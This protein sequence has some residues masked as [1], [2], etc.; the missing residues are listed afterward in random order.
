MIGRPGDLL[1]GRHLLGQALDLE[2]VEVP[3]EVLLGDLEQVRR[4]LL[5]LGPDLAA[6]PGRRS[7]GDRRGARAVGAEAVGRGVGV[8]LLDLDQLG[9]DADL[10]RQDLGV[11]GLVRLALA[12]GAEPRDR[13]AGGMDPDLAGIE[14]ADAQDVAVAGRPGADDLGEERDADAHQ[15]APRPLLR[16]LP[17]QALVADGGHG[18]A[19]GRRIVA[20]VVLPAERRL[21]RE[22]RRLDEVLQPQLGRVDL[23]L[24][25]QHVDDALDQIGRLGDP[26]RAAIGDAARRL[27][28]V[29]AVDATWAVGMS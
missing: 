8:A 3:L 26:E 10:G 29:H 18:L 19:H 16:L 6:D 21:I 17:A 25:R 23:Q 9:R 7:A 22:L 1:H 2:A 15:L 27:V 28:G 14:H 12:L 5:R 4:D 13:A 20:G 24:V 11:G